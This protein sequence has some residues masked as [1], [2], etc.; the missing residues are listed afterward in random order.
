MNQMTTSLRSFLDRP[1]LAVALALLFAALF[2]RHVDAQVSTGLGGDLSGKPSDARVVGID[3]VPVDLSGGATG[4]VLTIQDGVIVPAESGGGSGPSSGLVWTNGPTSS[5]FLGTSNVTVFS[6][7]VS[8]SVCEPPNFLNM[9]FG[10]TS[11]ATSSLSIEAQLYINGRLSSNTSPFTVS[12]SVR[13]VFHRAGFYF[14]R[15]DSGNYRY[16][17]G[18]MAVG[19]N[20]S[21]SGILT[22]LVAP[23][24]SGNIIQPFPQTDDD[25]RFEYCYTA[26]NNNPGNVIESLVGRAWLR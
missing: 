4:D 17:H 22:T 12:G 23:G 15:T 11:N 2:G 18:G 19:N 14:V 5:Q 3:G 7:N 21:G 25:I 13:R 16:W 10:T 6:F 24:H 9:E 26:I 20:L 1:F 8:S